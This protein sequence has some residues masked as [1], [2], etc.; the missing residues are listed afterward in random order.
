MKSYSP[1]LE[2]TRKDPVTGLSEIALINVDDIILV[3]CNDDGSARVYFRSEPRL[4]QFMDPVEPYSFFIT[5]LTE[6]TAA[7]Q[8]GPGDG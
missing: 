5:M 2:L 6:L 1:F 8:P 4:S 7:Q 3:R